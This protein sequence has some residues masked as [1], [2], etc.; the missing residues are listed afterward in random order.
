VRQL[1]SVVF[2]RVEVGQSHLEDERQADELASAA[3]QR[4]W[5]LACR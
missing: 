3:V 4:G 2:D 1:I 5:V